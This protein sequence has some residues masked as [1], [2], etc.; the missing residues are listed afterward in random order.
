MEGS[1]D[2]ELFFKLAKGR[3]TEEEGK[4]RCRLCYELRLRET[5]KRAKAGGFDYFATTLT[6]SPKK[7][8]EVLNEIGL[9]LEQEYLVPYLVSDFKKKNGYFRSVE[10]SKE[11]GLYR[12]NFCGCVYSK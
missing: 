3:E 1:Y 7:R 6:V 10:L 9:M 5:A 4:E 8:A 11:Y 2:T 12:Q